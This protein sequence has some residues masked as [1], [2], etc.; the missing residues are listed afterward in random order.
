M[1]S[2]TSEMVC[3][4]FQPELLCVSRREKAQLEI[5][6][7]MTPTTEKALPA[8]EIL[9]VGPYGVLGTGVLDA[10]AANAAWPETLPLT[11]LCTVNKP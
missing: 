9:L 8:R 3:P 7:P 11:D 2:T 5:M 4:G 6:S 1:V 10:A